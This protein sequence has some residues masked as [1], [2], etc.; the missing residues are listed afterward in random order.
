[1]DNIAGYNRVPHVSFI[2]RFHCILCVPYSGNF[3]VVQNFALFT[4]YRESSNVRTTYGLNAEKARKL[5]PRTF[6]L[7]VMLAKEFAPAK[8][9]HHMVAGF[10]GSLY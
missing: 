8:I 6:L 5:K 1:M 3:R 9:S 7:E 2:R 10:I 4:I